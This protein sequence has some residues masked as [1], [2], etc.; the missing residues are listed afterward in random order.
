MRRAVRI[1]QGAFTSLAHKS[2]A[3]L[4]AAGA[5]E[6][7]CGLGVQLAAVEVGLLQSTARFG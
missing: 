3:A 7:G 2:E 4:R 5:K 6:E 1:G